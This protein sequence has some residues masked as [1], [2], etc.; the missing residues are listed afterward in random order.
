MSVSSLLTGVIFAYFNSFGKLPASILSLKIWDRYWENISS[1]SFNILTGTSSCGAAFLV[2][3][4]LISLAVTSL[5]TGTKENLAEFL[6]YCFILKMLG[7]LLYFLLRA[8][9]DQFHLGHHKRCFHFFQC[10]MCSQCYQK[11]SC[12]FQLFL[13]CLSKLY[14]LQ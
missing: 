2:S 9:T 7:C 5:S 4:F 1:F 14:H 13:H 12:K 8:I 3:K 10:L 11:M 6:K